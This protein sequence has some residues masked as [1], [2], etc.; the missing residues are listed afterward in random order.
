MAL[1]CWQAD[2]CFWMLQ[3]LCTH[4]SILSCLAFICWIVHCIALM[5][6]RLQPVTPAAAGC[7]GCLCLLLRRV[8]AGGCSRGRRQHISLGCPESRRAGLLLRGGCSILIVFCRHPQAAPLAS[9]TLVALTHPC[10]YAVY[11]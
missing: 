6:F 7:G 1:T 3:F 9:M 10:I 11:R 2:S 8:G 5:C 4:Y